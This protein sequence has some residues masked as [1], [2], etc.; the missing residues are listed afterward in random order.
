MPS[1]LALLIAAALFIYAGLVWQ[2]P[3]PTDRA[4]LTRAVLTGLLLASALAVV[5]LGLS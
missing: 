4:R 1:S 3:A 5:R 2:Q